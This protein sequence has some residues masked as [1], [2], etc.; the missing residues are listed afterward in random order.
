MN[1]T[2]DM[3]AG[4]GESSLAINTIRLLTERDYYFALDN[5]EKMYP[6]DTT[7]I[8]N[9]PLVDG[10]RTIVRF[11]PLAEK[12]IGYEYNIKVIEIEN[13]DCKDLIPLTEENDAEAGNDRINIDEVWISGNY[14]NVAYLFLEGKSEQRPHLL[15]MVVDKNSADNDEYVTLQFRHNA[16][17][18]EQTVTH[19]GLISFKLDAIA[20]ELIDKKGVRVIV[21]SIY[22]GERT[23]TVKK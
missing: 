10:Q 12:K 19:V 16:H 2:N 15:N 4:E 8:L 20:D 6:G 21:N 17:N 14:L 22:D 9:Y 13:I 23:Y 1:D 3:P 18:D 11:L 5:G 7:S